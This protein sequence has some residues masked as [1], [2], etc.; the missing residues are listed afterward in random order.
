MG[1]VGGVTQSAAQ[2][3][4]LYIAYVERPIYYLFYPIVSC[5]DVI[6]RDDNGGTKETIRNL[7]NRLFI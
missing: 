1:G 4:L 2:Y 3:L 7:H 6:K 5:D